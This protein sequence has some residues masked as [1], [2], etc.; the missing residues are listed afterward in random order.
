MLNKFLVIITWL[1]CP[2]LDS[3]EGGGGSPLAA[4]WPQTLPHLGLLSSPILPGENL[5]DGGSE[6]S[7]VVQ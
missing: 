1:D 2:N 3:Q 7:G 5:L 4:S 6:L